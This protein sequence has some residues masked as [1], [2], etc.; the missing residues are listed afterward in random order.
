VNPFS[1]I[2]NAFNLA[3]THARDLRHQAIEIVH[4][5]G[6]LSQA[7]FGGF[8]DQTIVGSLPQVAVGI[9]VVHDKVADDDPR[10][11]R[12]FE[13]LR[14]APP[15]L[16]AWGSDTMPSTLSACASAPLPPRMRSSWVRRLVSVMPKSARHKA[17]SVEL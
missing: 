15:S 2:S 11:R 5:H 13:M 17:V 3:I 10:F 8:N 1:R 9:R 6:E 7:D 12:A 16:V 4:L 14:A